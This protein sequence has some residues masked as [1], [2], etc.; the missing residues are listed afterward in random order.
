MSHLDK[1]AKRMLSPQF[2]QLNTKRSRSVYIVEE[3]PGGT[4]REM[5]PSARHSSVPGSS[6]SGYSDAGGPS[7][8]APV[9]E[10]AGFGSF[11]NE[12]LGSNDPTPKARLFKN[13]SATPRADSSGSGENASLKITDQALPSQPPARLGPGWDLTEEHLKTLTVREK[14]RKGI[15][16]NFAQSLSLG[17][18]LQ[19]GADTERGLESAV[20]VTGMMQRL[21]MEK[22]IDPELSHSHFLRP[23]PN[24]VDMV[25]RALTNKRPGAGEPDNFRDLKTRHYFSRLPSV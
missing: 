1:E 18:S 20:T 22:N 7:T 24:E 2:D 6:A 17:E 14:L 16:M 9:L 12:T 13:N 15:A 25:N 5:D 10:S 23:G 4:M 19:D 11:G 21:D 3:S 8:P